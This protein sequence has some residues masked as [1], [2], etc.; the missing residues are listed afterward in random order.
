M[1][2]PFVSPA[3]FSDPL[4]MICDTDMAQ[5][6]EKFKQLVKERYYISKYTNISYSD[7]GGMTPLERDYL[8]GFILEEM[9]KEQK[10]LAERQNK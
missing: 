4:L 5:N 6:S 8:A 7:T 2:A 9:E 1:K 10:A 3:N